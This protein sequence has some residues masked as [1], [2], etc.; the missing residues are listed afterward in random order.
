MISEGPFQPKPFCDSTVVPVS[1]DWRKFE[2]KGQ[3]RTSLFP[4]GDDPGVEDDR[5]TGC[6]AAG[7]DSRLQE[8]RE[9]VGH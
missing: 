9:A 3:G 4:S 7:S 6:H 1:Y 5:G 2:G 8:G